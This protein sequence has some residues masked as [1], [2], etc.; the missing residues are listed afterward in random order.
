[1]PRAKMLFDRFFKNVIPYPVDYKEDL[2]Y[3]V[4]SFLPNMSDL[5]NSTK[6]IREYL[7]I[8]YYF[9]ILKVI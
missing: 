9:V 8:L 5:E 4:R 6:A 2:R 7:G 1:M 3:N